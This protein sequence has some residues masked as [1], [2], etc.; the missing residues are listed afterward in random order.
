MVVAHRLI[1]ERTLAMGFKPFIFK[2]DVTK[3]TKTSLEVHLFY[4]AS[5]AFF[6]SLKSF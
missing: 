6:D 2:K 5:F 1:L 3:L 4:L